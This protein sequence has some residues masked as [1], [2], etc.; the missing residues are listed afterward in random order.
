MF[1][2]PKIGMNCMRDDAA[3]GP[4][5]LVFVTKVMKVMRLGMDESKDWYYLMKETT[6]PI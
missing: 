2:A 6:P 3:I 1:R 5:Q 4:R